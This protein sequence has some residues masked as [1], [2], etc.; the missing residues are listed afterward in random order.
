MQIV[1]ALSILS[2][3]LDPVPLRALSASPE[4]PRFALDHDVDSLTTAR[5]ATFASVLNRRRGDGWF[6][7]LVPQLETEGR[8]IPYQFWRGRLGLETGVDLPLEAGGLLSLSGG[9]EHESDH[10]T[11][12]LGAGFD[13]TERPIAVVLNN[14]LLRTDW[15][16]PVGGG[17]LSTTGIGRLHVLTCTTTFEDCPNGTTGDVGV[18]ATAEVLWA[19]AEPLFG[20]FGTFAAAAGTWMGQRAEIGGERR[21]DLR[22]GIRQIRGWRGNWQFALW[23]RQGSPVGVERG[24]VR[25]EARYGISVGFAR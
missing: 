1:L 18:E 2:L 17:W 24:I 20:A 15:I 19:Q 13:A 6:L 12:D 22:L 21:L 23:S 11:V 4:A 7:A 9:L 25:Q 10:R 16:V 8:I 14:L 5:F 3:P